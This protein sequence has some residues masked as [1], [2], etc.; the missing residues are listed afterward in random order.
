MAEQSTV[1]DVLDRPMYATD[2]DGVMA[3]NTYD[4]LN[5]ML[6]RGYPDGG[7]EKFAYSAR[8]LIAY[9][10]ELNFTNFYVYDEAGRK[11]FE[12]NANGQVLRYTNNAAGDLLSLTDGKNQ[13]TRWKYDEYGRTTN[14]QDQITI[15][16]KYIYDPNNRLTNRWSAAKGTTTYKYD[17]V[18]NLTNVVYPVG[19]TSVKLRYDALNRVTNMVDGIGT[20]VYTYA[21]GGE[22]FTENGPWANDTVTNSYTYRLRTGLSLQQSA[23]IWTNAFGYDAAK[24]LTNVTS[25]AGIFSY[26]LGGP[27]SASALAREVLLPN[28]SYITNT[29]D[30]NARL[31]STYLET[32]G[33]SILDSAVYTNN[34]ANQRVSAGLTNASAGLISYT[35]DPIGQLKVANSSLAIDKRGYSYDAAWN[36]ATR[37]NNGALNETF[38]VNSLNEL[39]SENSTNVYDSYD[40]NGNLQQRMDSGT[41]GYQFFF[42]AEDR[43]TQA[44]Q[45]YSGAY[46]GSVVF[47]YDGLG[48][49]R[50]RTTY[51]STGFMLAQVGYVYDGMRVI[52]ERN[53]TSTPQVSYTRGTDLSG[54]LE[55]AGGIGGLLARSD[56]YSS[57]NFTRHNYYHADGNGN[58]TY[59]ETSAQGL[60]ASYR[61]D[62]FGNTVAQSGTVADA[63]VYRFSSKEWISLITGYPSGESLYY[64]GYRFYFPTLQRWLNRDPVGELGFRLVQSLQPGRLSHNANLYKF[65]RND[66]IDNCDPDGLVGMRVERRNCNLLEEEECETQCWPCGGVCFVLDFYWVLPDG[67]EDFAYSIHGCKCNKPPPGRDQRFKPPQYPCNRCH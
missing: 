41:N 27:S 46:M 23:G 11:T 52:Q 5:R 33:N 28:S 18:G 55:G 37:T 31:L 57:G 44:D 45:Y 67:E 32:S 60:A 8:G 13:T 1:F 26:I 35:Y 51:D 59:L 49:L 40:N 21:D 19:T 66:P 34:L 24:R 20:T 15:E 64:Y 10:N 62:P 58:I 43:L 63:N 47:Q 39:L 9:T 29:Y 61:Y 14:K 16:F 12:T 22:L 4:A 53:G 6:T 7:V 17:N 56:L 54:T 36:M 42:D 30:G 25:P 38:I 48:R 2:A 3:T 65:L 50:L